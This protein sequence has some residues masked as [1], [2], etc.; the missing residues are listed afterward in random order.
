[1]STSLCTAFGRALYKL[2][3]YLLTYYLLTQLFTYKG[4]LG[5]YA[6]R[7]Q[8]LVIIIPPPIVRCWRHYAFALSVH[9]C[10]LHACIHPGVHVHLV[11]MLLYEPMDGISPNFG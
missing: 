5:H 6:K 3:F 10:M 2:T 7:L 11:N 1:M 9:E 8:P 4:L